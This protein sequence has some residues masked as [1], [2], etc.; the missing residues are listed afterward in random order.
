MRITKLLAVAAVASMGLFAAACG[1]SD[2]GDNGS[3]GIEVVDNPSFEAGTTM[4]RLSK[5]GTVKIGTKFDQPGFGMADLDGKPQGFDVE[6]G[7]IIAGQLGISAD[8]I[9]WVE[10]PS[11]VREENIEQGKVDFVV[12]TYTINDKRKDR[13]DFAGPYYEAGQA[14][15][16]RKG[17]DSI[18]GPDDL[19]E[20]NKKVCSVTGSTPAANIRQF[21]NNESEQLVLFDT[22]DKCVDALKNKQVDTVTTDNVILLGYI[23][24]ADGAYELAGETFTNE[25]Y[26]IGVTKGDNAFRGF[27]NDTLEKAS[28]EGWYEDAWKRTAGEFDKNTPKLPAL[29]RY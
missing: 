9:E 6:I 1:D 15:M 10:T 4:E 11:A 27:I 21:L 3:S 20:G 12:A 22:Y 26:G 24:K 18:N 2:D 14:L 29:D 7:K 17:D 28:D 5:Q 8:K 19:K 23:S 25:P 13:V 16:V